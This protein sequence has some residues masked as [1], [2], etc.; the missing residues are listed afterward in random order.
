[1]ANFTILTNNPLTAEKYPTVSVFHD[2]T[3]E[4]IFKAARD[5]IHMG[6]LILGHPLSGSVKP[7][8]SP[9]KSLV[10]SRPGDELDMQSLQL[11]EGALAVLYKL[12]IKNRAYPERAMED[13][14]VIDLDLLD[15]AIKG[16]PPQY[17]L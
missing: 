12:G 6:A 2:T 10:L 5:S 15:S 17:H 16:L 13:F 1:M 14:K 4:D 8:E 9:F 11:I 3:V 7:N